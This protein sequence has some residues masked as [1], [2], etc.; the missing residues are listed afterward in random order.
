MAGVKVGFYCPSL[1]LY[2]PCWSLVWK[3]WYAGLL[4]ILQ[5]SAVEMENSRQVPEFFPLF[6]FNILPSHCLFSDFTF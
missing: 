4:F 2:S 5:A 3:E 6:T 1:S